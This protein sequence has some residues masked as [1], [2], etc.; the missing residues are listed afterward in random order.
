M[1]EEK[2]LPGQD[3]EAEIRKAVR[4]SH[5]VLV[6][7]SKSSLTKEGYVQK[8]IRHA[9]DV[10]DEKPDGTIFVIPVRLERCEVPKNDCGVGNGWIYSILGAT[11]DC[12][13][14]C[15][16]VRK[17]SGPILDL[18]ILHRTNVFSTHYRPQFCI[19]YGTQW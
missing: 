18:S 13:G 2:L 19:Q 17:L 15:T 9:L 7:I 14:L 10:A 3:W 5:V 6:C 4:G 8:E 12:L 11:K 16:S 1:D